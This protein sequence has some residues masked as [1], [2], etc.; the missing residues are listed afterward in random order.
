MSGYNNDFKVNGFHPVIRPSVDVWCC[1]VT[2]STYKTLF[3]M[4]VF[5]SFGSKITGHGYS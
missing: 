1:A 2:L 4:P 3:W 5:V